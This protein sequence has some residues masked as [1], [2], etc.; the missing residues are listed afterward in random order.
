MLSRVLVY[1]TYLLSGLLLLLLLGIDRNDGLGQD[2]LSLEVRR[3]DNLGECVN[4]RLY[5]TNPYST[6]PLLLEAQQAARQQQALKCA[7]LSF[8]SQAL[9]PSSPMVWHDELMHFLL[10]KNDRAPPHYTFCWGLAQ[11][12]AAGS[13]ACT[14]MGGTVTVCV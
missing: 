3:R 14:A 10:K 13:A 9:Q 11:G 1:M 5:C 12:L 4:Y 6:I 8:A 7:D 2:K